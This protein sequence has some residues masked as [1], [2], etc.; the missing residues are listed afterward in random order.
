MAQHAALGT[1]HAKAVS[2]RG[3]RNTGFNDALGVLAR[4]LQRGLVARDEIEEVIRGNCRREGRPAPV[5]S[6]LQRRVERLRATFEESGVHLEALALP[7]S[8]CAVGWQMRQWAVT[9]TRCR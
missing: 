7:G 1:A 2:R 8:G 5:G 4:L 6:S 9:P 3:G